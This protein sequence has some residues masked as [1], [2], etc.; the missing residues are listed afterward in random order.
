MDTIDNF[1]NQPFAREARGHG[2]ISRLQRAPGKGFGL[3][4]SFIIERQLG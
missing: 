3:T 4:K 1:L 2:V